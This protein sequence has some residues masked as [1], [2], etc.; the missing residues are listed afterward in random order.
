MGQFQSSGKSYSSKSHILCNEKPPSCKVP[1]REK[2]QQQSHGVVDLQLRRSAEQH[3]VNKV[4]GVIGYSG[5]P[6]L[7]MYS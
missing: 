2:V 3:T 1:R 7:G 6:F 5:S 4:P